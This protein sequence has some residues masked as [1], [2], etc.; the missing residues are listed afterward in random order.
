[1]SGFQATR[2]SAAFDA[3]AEGGPLAALQAHSELLQARPGTVDPGRLWSLVSSGDRLAR[4]LAIRPLARFAG[5][6]LRHGRCLPSRSSDDLLLR[7]QALWALADRP[8]TPTGVAA[9]IGA[10]AEG[11]HAAMLAQLTI[12]RWAA[13]DPAVLAAIP[14]ALADHA[15]D[16]ARV[17]LVETATVADHAGLAPLLTRLLR[18]TDEPEVVRAA[19]ARGLAAHPDPTAARRS[20]ARGS[21]RR[22]RAAV[23]LR[24]RA[25]RDPQRPGGRGGCSARH[26]LDRL[27]RAVRSAS[28]RAR[29]RSLGD[30]APR[31]GPGSGSRRSSC[32][33]GSTAS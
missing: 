1:M 11:G 24:P 25:P 9:A 13:S 4:A 6:R 28:G 15:E 22:A 7:E 30:P 26:G 5:A 32:R 17:R 2:S 33:A 19:A 27:E 18:S 14:A 31:R 21:R 10:I 20:L 12:E 29:A 23:C 16:D 8:A 3:L